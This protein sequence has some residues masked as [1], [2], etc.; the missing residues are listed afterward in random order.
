MKTVMAST[1]SVSIGV[2]PWFL[3]TSTQLGAAIKIQCKPCATL[4]TSLVFGRFCAFCAFSRPILVVAIG[5]AHQ[6]PS[7]SKV[8]KAFQ[9]KRPISP[10]H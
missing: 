7:I 6:N 2:H 8:F 9:S 10:N 5:P 4:L 3:S 1:L